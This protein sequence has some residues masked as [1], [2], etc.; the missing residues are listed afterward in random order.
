LIRIA[1]WYSTN[2][3]RKITTLEKGQFIARCVA[4][5]LA[6]SE[7]KSKVYRRLF[8][9]RN[10]TIILVSEWL[11]LTRELVDLQ[12]T[13][14][15]DPKCEETRSRYTYLCWL[16]RITDEDRL[17]TAYRTARF[18]FD[19]ALDFRDQIAEKY[20]RMVT[21][22]AS[23]H[24][25]EQ[26][27]S[28]GSRQSLNDVAQNFMLAV[29]RAIDKCDYNKGT[30]TN[31]VERWLTNAKTTNTFRHEV[32]TAYTIPSGQRKMLATGES[33]FGNFAV[34]LDSEEAKEAESEH[35]QEADLIRRDTI[36]QVRKLARSVDPTG[37]GRLSLG[38]L[39]SL[40]DNEIR[41]LQ[42]HNQQAVKYVNRCD[43]NAVQAGG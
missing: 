37:L 38:I 14:T 11:D 22:Q 10:L 2:Q 34:S 1:S 3:R 29:Y 28:A 31:Y 13:L 30:L 8:I 5:G 35:N 4:F 39:E 41:L 20:M 18:Y 21:V 12:V 36:N 7:T 25:K 19:Q 17:F 40:N 32:G 43:R 23:M 24:F 33:C 42:Q 15:A 16:L 27:D 9:E 26:R 6:R